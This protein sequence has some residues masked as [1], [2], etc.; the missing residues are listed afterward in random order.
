MDLPNIYEGN[1]KRLIVLPILLVLIALFFIPRIEYGID[2]KGG[3]LITLHLTEDRTPD[4][5]KAAFE[6]NGFK[7]YKVTVSR[8]A[9]GLMAEVEIDLDPL[10]VNATQTHSEF[11]TAYYKVGMLKGIIRSL[12]DTI[13]SGNAT[14]DD[15]NRYHTY[16]QEYE[17]AQTQMTLSADRLFQ[18]AGLSNRTDDYQDLNE[19]KKAVDYAFTKIKGDYQERFNEVLSNSIPYDSISVDV[20]SPTL[21]KHFIDK[22]IRAVLISLFLSFILAFVV[23][24]NI[25]SSLI[26]LSGAFADVIISLGAMGLFGIP[27][28][29]PSFA[30]LLMLIGLSLDTDMLLSMR[31][32]KIKE[33]KPS[34]R[35]YS[36]LKTG[37]TMSL[38]D[39]IAFVI[40]FGIG[41]FAHISTYYQIGAVT[42]IGLIGDV[43]ATWMFNAVL[44][45][46]YVENRLEKHKHR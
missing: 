40:L 14:Q 20:V 35:A 10:I 21:A 38:T 44:V 22:A 23:F 37:A 18:M 46:W 31:V 2:F 13:N 4:Q 19:L 41:L 3:T 27:L 15:I 45:L 34:D 9:I 17:D 16:L 36:A 11:S 29:L 8:S 28:T 43:I 25:A 26:V 24:R 6:D 1:Y 12:N 30:A 5:I 32:V 39:F 33:G 42:S 7:V